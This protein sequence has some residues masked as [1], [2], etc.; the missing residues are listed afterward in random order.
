VVDSLIR[1]R[2]K[3]THLDMILEIINE[4]TLNKREDIKRSG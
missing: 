1:R 3:E 2:E 4:A